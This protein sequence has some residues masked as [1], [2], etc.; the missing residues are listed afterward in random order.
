MIISH[1]HWDH[2][3]GMDLF[4]NARIWLQ[5]DELHLL[6]RRR[7]AIAA[8]RTVASTPTTSSRSSSSISQG[9]VGFVDGDDQEILPGITCLHRRQAYLRLAVRHRQHRRRNR[10]AGQRQHVSLRES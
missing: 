4:P 8:I 7:L 2:A 5:K 1:M 9:R 3:D 6:R 10:R